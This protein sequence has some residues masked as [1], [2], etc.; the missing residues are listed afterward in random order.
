MHVPRSD[1]RLHARPSRERLR[2]R[3]GVNQLVEHGYVHRYRS[4]RLSV[5]HLRLDRF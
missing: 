4:R 2:R 5:R 3:Q 1:G